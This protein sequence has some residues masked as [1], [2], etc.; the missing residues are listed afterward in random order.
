MEEAGY[1]FDLASAYLTGRDIARMIKPKALEVIL[2]ILDK[3][4]TATQGHAIVLDVLQSDLALEAGLIE[5]TVPDKP[6][7]S[8][9]KYRLTD[10][11]R[12]V[13]AR[14]GGG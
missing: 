6:R 11:G 5:M 4:A 13:M 8:K 12:Q 9:Q 14:H 3:Q 7:S 2:E 10:K 1:D